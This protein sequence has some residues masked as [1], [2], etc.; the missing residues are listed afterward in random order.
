MRDLPDTFT[1]AEAMPE[2]LSR[3]RLW[4]LQRDGKVERV[5]RGLYRRTDAPLADAD[6]EDSPTCCAA[7]TRSPGRRE[8]SCTRCRSSSKRTLHQQ[9]Y[10]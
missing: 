7:Q 9:Q 1:P 10:H 3:Q 2:G 6:P 4:E 8:P 5:A